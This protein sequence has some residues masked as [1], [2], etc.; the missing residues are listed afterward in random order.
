MSDPLDARTLIPGVRAAE[1]VERPEI[2][3]E[4]LGVGHGER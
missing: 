2:L 3:V 4:R 1:R